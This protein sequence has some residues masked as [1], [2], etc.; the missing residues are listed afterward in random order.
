MNLLFK[1]D[2]YKE[3]LQADLR[4]SIKYYTKM[5]A[6]MILILVVSGTLRIAP[7]IKSDLMEVATELTQNFPADLT[8]TIA[9]EGITS[10][11]SFPLI[12]QTPKILTKEDVNAGWPRNL[13]V[14]DPN[15]EVGMLKEYDALML[16]NNSYI[17]INNNGSVQTTPLN[18]MPPTTIN[19]GVVKQTVDTLTKI[20]SGAYFYTS[21]FLGASWLVNFFVVRVIYL[22]VFAF[23]VWLMY[24][25]TFVVYAKAFAVSIHT[26]TLP[27]I[28]YALV[29]ALGIHIP[30]PGWFVLAHTLFTLYI[31]DRLEK[32]PQS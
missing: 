2:Y 18:N 5:S 27:L 30:L 32:M 10:N 13:A 22:A 31:L 21:A 15:G 3:V 6:V 28:V 1:P 9:P 24:K 8:L 20:S 19:A 11:K 26:I 12:V 17:I 4:Q 29:E 7:V 14:I 16:I 23:V 25:S